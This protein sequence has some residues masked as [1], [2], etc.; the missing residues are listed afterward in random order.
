RQH[1]GLRIDDAGERGVKRRRARE[2]RLERLSRRAV[3]PRELDA[4]GLRRG[5]DAG[6]A[7]QL[8]IGRGDDELFAAPMRNG[9]PG[10]ELVEPLTPSDAQLRLERAR[11][12]VDAGVDHLAVARTRPGAEARGGF[13]DQHLAP[14]ERQLPRHREAHDAGADPAVKAIV[15]TGEG[16]TFAA[17]ADINE[18]SS[19]LVLKSPITREVQARMEAASKPLVAAIE[20]VALGGGFEL[21][22]ACHWRIAATTAKVGLPEVKLGLLPGAGGTQRFTRLA[23]PEAALEAI[24]AGHQ[25]PAPRALE[26]GLVDALADPALDGALAFARRAVAE[27]RP[28]RVTS[29]VGERIRGVDPELFAAFRRKLEAKARGQ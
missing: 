21:A 13:E 26:L 15:V 17:G 28:L 2:L 5:G 14:G 18:V 4:V 7:R 20:G 10:A 8:G 22:L 3:E 16:G 9:A 25:I 23:G 27:R 12:I 6:E 29:D 1:A 11:R 19:G 24:T